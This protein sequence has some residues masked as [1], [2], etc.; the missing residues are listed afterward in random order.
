MPF[1]GIVTSSI[2]YGLNQKLTGGKIEKIYQPEVDELIFLVHNGKFNHKLLISSG[3]SHSRLHLITSSKSN[4]QNPMAFCMLLRKHI[5]NGRIQSICQK[6]SERIIEITIE[7]FNEM[8]FPIN[9]KLIIEIMGKHSNIILIDES[10][11]KI[12]DSIKRI[13]SDV[14]RYRQTLP[15][16]QYV[17]PPVQ[18]K[19]SYFDLTE[20]MFNQ[21]FDSLSSTSEN[22]D[23]IFNQ[24]AAAKTLVASIQGISPVIA[25]EM[26]T[27]AS[28]ISRLYALLKSYIQKLLIGDFS[29]RV[30]LNESDAPID[31]YCFN[32]YDASSFYKEVHFSD[33]QEAVEYFYDHKDSSNKMKQKSMD[34]TK[35]LSSSLEKLYLK[36]QKLSQDLLQAESS[37]I[38]KLF[39]ELLT[40]NM[41]VIP[42]KATEVHVVNYYNDESLTITLDSRLTASQNAQRYYKKYAKSKVAIQEKTIQLGEA[43]KDIIYL[44]SV[45]THIEN[46]S[47]YE[48]IEEIRQEVVDGGYMKKKK[49]AFKVSKVKLTPYAY[50]STD[51]FR[52]LVGR[53]NK[54]N[55]ALTF[56]TAS[57]KDIW[58]HTKDI[59]GSHVIIFTEGRDVPESTIK[60]A[61]SLAAYYSKARLSENVPVD[62]TQV[63][64]VKK[65]AGAKP[66]MV[67]F[68]NN[69]TIYVNPYVAS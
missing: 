52:I 14:N 40:A 60:L 12:I 19:I 30:Y 50:T 63:R 34:L 8:G 37:E 26:C 10:S 69:K 45:L 22:N 41:Y 25:R 3:S 59:P 42:S 28:S 31:F 58:L 48:D 44:E 53:N 17:Y 57:N 20:D 24:D 11:N 46:A 29:P 56:K 62:Y 9:K 18:G 5:Q 49:N 32:L 16:F 21:L 33:I 36:K 61:A 67:I 7:S 51:G 2:T 66:G 55:D 39:G 13:H 64:H 54:E 27:K 38:F 1:D 68:V 35:A 43:G 23:A 6:D 15:G 47:S 4:P 65:P